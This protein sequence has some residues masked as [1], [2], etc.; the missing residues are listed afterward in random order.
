MKYSN[1]ST[2][3]EESISWGGLTSCRLGFA[4]GQLLKAAACS[5]LQHCAVLDCAVLDCAVLDCA[6]L[7]CADAHAACAATLHAYNYT[8]PVK[9]N[10]T[11]G[12]LQSWNKFCFTGK[13]HRVPG[14]GAGQLH[15]A[16]CDSQAAHHG[17]CHLHLLHYTIAHPP[18]PPPSPP[19]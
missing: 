16:D 18:F 11:S 2:G 5:V 1:D 13:G 15:T 6:V 19:H 4:L 10:F 3:M 9:K 7:D 17:Y 14:G 8:G 12:M